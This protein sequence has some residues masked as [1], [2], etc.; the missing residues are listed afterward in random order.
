MLATIGRHLPDP[1][2]RR[3]RVRRLRPAW[4]TASPTGSCG[5]TSPSWPSGASA[6]R[7]WR[8]GSSSG[9]HRAP[10]WP[11]SRLTVRL[12]R[13][14]PAGC[15]MG[16]AGGCGE[17]GR[18]SGRRATPEVVAPADGD[19]EETARPGIPAARR[20][21]GR[22]AATGTPAA[23]ASASR[24]QIGVI[25]LRDDDDPARRLGEQRHAS[26]R[27]LAGVDPQ[28]ETH[29]RARR[30]RVRSPPS[31]TSCTPETI[32]RATNP[33][34]RAAAARWAAAIERLQPAALR[35]LAPTPTGA[36]EAELPVA[37]RPRAAARRRR[38]AGRA[39]AAPRRSSSIRPTTPTTGVGSMSRPVATRC[40][41]SRCRRRRGCRARGT[42]RSCRRS[43]RRTATSPRGARGC[44]S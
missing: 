5:Q 15:S 13:S 35:P 38:R 26:P 1:P 32:R 42:R 9:S 8:C 37:C 4:P 39:R 33:R 27:R 23:S 2:L 7:S 43:P 24:P 20:R 28:P 12:V 19:V 31:A 10:T 44:R 17:R 29:A 6:P 34:T 14:D 18:A 3:R 30:G 25:A 11:A 21:H 16:R 36:G 40:R 41:S 22:D